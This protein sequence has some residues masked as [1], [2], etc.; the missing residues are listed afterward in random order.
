M[1]G[2]DLKSMHSQSS[3][4]LFKSLQYVKLLFTS[5]LQN[6]NGSDWVCGIFLS[7]VEFSFLLHS[8]T[9]ALQG[10]RKF[11]IAVKGQIAE[12]LASSIVSNKSCEGYLS[13]HQDDIVLKMGR[14]KKFWDYSRKW[15]TNNNSYEFERISRNWV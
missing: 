11:P 13:P 2:S 9:V 4:I 15:C 3:F 5:S 7:E 10:F 14:L 1:R 8:S 6:V 12:S